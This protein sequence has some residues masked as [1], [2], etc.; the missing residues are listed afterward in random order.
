MG[1]LGS[2]RYSRILENESIENHLRLDIRILHRSGSLKPGCESDWQWFSQGKLCAELRVRVGSGQ[3]VLSYRHQTSKQEWISEEYLVG[4]DWTPCAY[5]GSRVWFRCPKKGCGR[6]VALL[7]GREVLACRHCHGISYPCQRE[8]TDDRVF[9]RI[10][11]L[12]ERLGWGRGVLNGEG[13]KPKH[14]HWSTFSRLL[15]EYRKYSPLG[16]E[17]AKTSQDIILRLSDQFILESPHR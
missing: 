5:G 4:L 8:T 7:Y 15:A 16:L 11:R 14:M 6:R 2:G 13:E 3:V 12:R 1:G 9:R 10:E 17:I